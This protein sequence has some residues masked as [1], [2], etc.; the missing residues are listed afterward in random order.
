MTAAYTGPRTWL[1]SERHDVYKFKNYRNDMQT[2]HLQTNVNIVLKPS[3][4]FDFRLSSPP[5][6]FIFI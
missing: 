1:E 6:T 5:V 4:P 3:A 2:C